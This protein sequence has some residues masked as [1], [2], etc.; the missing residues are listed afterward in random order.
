MR[1]FGFRMETAA[2]QFYLMAEL[3]NWIEMEQAKDTEYFAGMVKRYMPRDWESG[4][5]I[6]SR[7]EIDNFLILVGKAECATCKSVQTYAS[8][9][10]ND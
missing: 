7:R 2:G 3:P 4:T 10:V 1:S 8:K 6:Q 9:R 5:N